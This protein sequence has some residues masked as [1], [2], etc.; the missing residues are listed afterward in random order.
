MTVLVTVNRYVAVCRPYAAS[1]T[2]SVKRQARQ[3]VALVATFSV[4]FNIT[5]FFEY[6]IK[7][8]KDLGLRATPTW[9]TM[10]FLY[11]V[12]YLQRVSKVIKQVR[13]YYRSGTDGRCYID[14]GK[15]ATHFC[16]K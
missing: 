15:T 7:D 5:R 11:K 10:N 8:V 13:V 14:A 4:L 6:E 16:V 1:D 9:L 12:T 3:H 2:N